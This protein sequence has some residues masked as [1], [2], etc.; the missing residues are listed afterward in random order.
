V[1]QYTF[2]G[3]HNHDPKYN[4]SKAHLNTLQILSEVFTKPK[5]K[6][7]LHRGKRR[8][9]CKEVLLRTN[10]QASK[11]TNKQT[12]IFAGRQAG[13]HASIQSRLVSGWISHVNQCRILWGPWTYLLLCETKNNCVE[14][15]RNAT[16]E[17]FFKLCRRK[18]RA[19]NPPSPPPL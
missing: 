5:T 8:F 9:P 12:N 19:E 6:N 15:E 4:Y 2:S 13:R 18:I 1:L 11:Q 17:L 10:K 3:S 16:K 14:D 7:C